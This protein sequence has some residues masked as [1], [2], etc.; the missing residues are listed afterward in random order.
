[1]KTDN[2]TDR[3]VVI[4]RVIDAPRELV[5]EAWT[6]PKHAD[7]WWGPNGFVNTTESMDLRVGGEWKYMM[8]G[9]DGTRYPNHMVYK[10]VTPPSKLVADHGDGERVWFEVSVTFQEAGSVKK[11]ATLVTLRQLFPSKE[12]RDE[13]V[14]KSGAIEGGKQHFAKLEAYLKENLLRIKES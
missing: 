9:P 11:Q 3:E 2:F 4:T 8:V 1:M 13:V 14:E 10:E 6:N 5:W 7:K 12:I